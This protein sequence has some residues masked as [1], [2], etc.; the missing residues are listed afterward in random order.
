MLTNSKF[1]PFLE[2]VFSKYQINTPLR[3]AHFLA[4]L[5]H[6]SG[7]F[8][9]VQESF[10]YKTNQRLFDIFPKYFDKDKNGKMSLSE[11]QTINSYIGKPEKLANFLYANRMGNGNEASGDGWK[12]RGKG[13][14]QLTG[15]GTQTE[16]AKYVGVDI[17]KSPDFLTEAK[18]AIDS[19][20]WFWMKRG[21]NKL[22]DDTTV[23]VMKDG[24]RVGPVTRI[25][26]EVNGGKNGL[27]DRI[28]NFNYYKKLLGV[29]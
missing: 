3:K 8:T 11:A 29:K 19:A 15:K 12:H 6:E 28:I 24:T 26:K 10:N 17:N 18:Y 7:N 27:E 2:E 21:L 4:Q 20:G 14:I 9:R 13:L 16:Y 25:T 23:T 1:E 22:A 5:K